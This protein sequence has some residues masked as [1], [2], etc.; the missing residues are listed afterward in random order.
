[1]G[2]TVMTRKVILNILL[3]GIL[4]CSVIAQP[5]SGEF[6]R[7]PRRTSTQPPLDNERGLREL[8]PEEIPPNLNFYAMDP[9]YDPNAVLGW[10]GERI[11]E[12]LNRGM[13]AIPIEDGKVYLCWRLLKTDPESIAFNI[14]RSTAGA[15]SV[16]LNDQPLTKT[17]NFLDDKASFEQSNAWFVKPVINGRERAASEL[18]E[19]PANPP[20]QQYKSIT[21]KDDVRVSM[22]G[23]ADL[24]GDGV[25]D[26]VVKHST[27]RSKD[28]GRTGP[29]TGAVQYDGYNGKTGEFM[30]RIDLGWNVDN[31]IWWTPMVIRDLDGDNKAEV[32]LRTSV[33]AAT[34]EDMLPSGEEGFLL[35]APEFM[36]VYNGETGELID[37][38]D[39]IELGKV[40]D[41]G[42]NTG[43]RASRHMLGIAYL[44]GKT[45]AVLAVRGTYGMMK[46][47]AYMLKNKKLE[48]IWRWTNERAPFMYQGQGQHSIKTADIDNDGCDEILNGSIAI[49]NDG[50]TMWGTG[51]GHGDRFYLGDIDPDRPGMEVLYIFEEPH[52]HNGF[53]LWDAGTGNLIWGIPAPNRD[54]ELSLAIAGDIDPAYPGME[55]AGGRHYYTAVG[56]QI[57]G[58]VPPLSFLVWW[59]S[60][61]LRE[62]YSRRGVI[63]WKGDTLTDISGSVQQIADIYG[64]WREEIITASRGELRI[65][66]T[67][68]PAAD[69]RICLM[70]D[71]LYRNDV[72]H[73][74]MGYAHYPMTS[75][76]LGTK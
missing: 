5:P 27:G 76:Y 44:D 16:K 29:N 70:Q 12:K 61:L 55:C 30:W 71:P 21:L 18:A 17:T 72:T 50:R 38:V 40:Q 2:V 13:L 24:N 73:R 34:R 49:N 11:E 65:Y 63:K 47:D 4:S 46:I 75:Y 60:D 37:K 51:Y 19:L 58:R 9:L 39:W 7:R 33:Y 42:D 14:Y 64:D 41:W 15:A 31:G 3:I 28:P 67:V 68:I 62:I 8:S 74:T 48:K 69:R 66:S 26:F 32:C 22:V 1:M 52:P 36:A 23:I 25:Y 20:I 54:N 56:Q 45:P 10:A 59:D 35:D 53:S 6:G 57:D 43:N